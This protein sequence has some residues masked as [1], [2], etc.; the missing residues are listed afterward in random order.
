MRGFGRILRCMV[1]L[2]VLLALLTGLSSVA[3]ADEKGAITK[4]EKSYEIAVVFDNSG[5]MY[6][7]AAWCRAKFAMEIFAS[8]LDYDNGDRL[9]VFPMWEVLTDGTKYGSGSYKPVQ[10]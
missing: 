6:N 7:T 10:T 3:L 4:Q 1:A 5:S 2:A 9:V 8:M